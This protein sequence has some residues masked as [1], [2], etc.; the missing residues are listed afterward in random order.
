MKVYIVVELNKDTEPKV[1]NVF[2]NKK[3]AEKEAYK[4]S[5][6]WRNIIERELR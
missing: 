3:D 2:K 1:L 4:D 6:A 5:K